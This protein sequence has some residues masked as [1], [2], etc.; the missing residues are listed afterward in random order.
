[1]DFSQEEQTEHQTGGEELGKNWK[2]TVG[3]RLEEE[4]KWGIDRF[5]L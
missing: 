4:K 1:M 3:F 2:A 5:N